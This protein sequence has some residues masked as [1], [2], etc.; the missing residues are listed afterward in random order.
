[1]I[2]DQFNNPVSSRR[3][4]RSAGNS[5]DRPWVPTR[6]DDIGNMIQE[7]ERRTLVAV[8]RM[9]VENWATA[10]AITRQI[11]MYSVGHAWKPT[12]ETSDTDLKPEVET[13][14]REQFCGM[15]DIH[16]RSFA[17]VLN[18]LS[19]T[20]LRDGDVFYLLTQRKSGFPAIQIIPSHRIGQRDRGETHVLRGKYRG[21]RIREGVIT[22]RYG[23]VVAYRLLGK[24]ADDDQEIS[25]A[26][27]KHVFKSDY[28]EGT[29]GYPVLA[30]ALNDGRDALQA[31]EWERLKMLAVSAHTLIEHNETGAPDGDPRNHFESDGVTPLADGVRGE[32]E[33]GTVHGGIYKTVRAASG[34]KLEALE[35]KTPGDVWES[36]QNRLDH[37]LSA[38]VP[39]PQ[40]FTGNGNGP[41]G[42]VAERR[43]IMQA[44]KTIENEQEILK[45]HARTIISYA[46]KKLVKLGRVEDSPDW[47]RWSFSMPPKLTVDDGRVSKAMLEM[48]RAGVVNDEDILDE[49][50]KDHDEHYRNRF[51]KAA[52]K[53]LMFED[54]QQAKGVELDTRLKGMFTPNDTNDDEDSADD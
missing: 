25:S 39:W 13:L 5:I 8:S 7:Y 36:Y 41:G 42:G 49:M 29:R 52:D 50:G 3:F 46:Y 6:L 31:H 2:V 23:T 15:A 10:K 24:T 11:P 51:N 4:N 27:L 44:R 22:D 33:T 19:H 35:H 26:F 34:Y 37:K 21:K 45:P 17:T 14:I 9:L 48:W 54:V 38:G 40:S 30:H 1:M 32:I 16:G 53:N 47:W 12:F 43:D 20:R 28:P 18:Q